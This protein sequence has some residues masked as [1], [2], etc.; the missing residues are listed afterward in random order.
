MIASSSSTP[1]RATGPSLARLVG[2]V[3]VER[4]LHHPADALVIIGRQLELLVQDEHLPADL[5]FGVLR[6]SLFRL[7]QGR[8][9]QLSRVCRSVTVYGEADI[10]P[11][12][13]PGVTFVALQPNTPLCQEW[14]LIVDSPGF[15]AALLTQAVAE[16]TGGTMRRYR[17]EGALSADERIVKRAGLLLS[18]M[19]Q[20]PMAPVVQRDHFANKARW[21][22]IAYGLATHP[23]C[24][25]LNLLPSL[26][27]LPYLLEILTTAEQ[28]DEQTLAE[29]IQV[30]RSA[31]TLGELCYRSDGN[32]LNPAVWSSTRPMAAISATQ[33]LAG[34][35]AQQGV[36]ALGTLL[37]GSLDQELLPDALSAIAVPIYV[38]GRVWGVL[39]AGLHEPEP[40]DAPTAQ[41]VVAVAALLGQIMSGRAIQQTSPAAMPSFAAATAPAVAAPPSRAVVPTVPANGAASPAKT[42]PTFSPP[43]FPAA[44]FQALNGSA[45]NTQVEAPA[46]TAPTAAAPGGF[47]L[48]A[49]MRG[50]QVAAPPSSTVAPAK[51]IP[52]GLVL[53]APDPFNDR[54]WP[55]LQKRMMGALIAFDQ[56][57]AEYV[58]QE[59]CGVYAT[60]EICTE[61]LMPVQIAV[62]E[63]WHRGEV[64][65]AAEHFTS[66]FV[67]GKL[68][69]LLNAYVDSPGGPLAVIGC[70]Q[71]ELHEL[72]A[73]MLSLF[74]RWSGFRVIYLGQNVPNTTIEEAIRQIRP[75]VLGLSATTI[76]AAHS[77]TEV[78][79]II[80]RVEPP[81]P[82][83][84]F[85]GMAFYERPDL[86]SR[87]AGQFLEG[88]IRQI[89]RQLADTFRK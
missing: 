1:S 65:V 83:F 61:L 50:G 8:I 55:M 82:M 2:D 86:R 23:E 5:S 33:G 76:E 26:Y 88:D 66:R 74:M 54:S 47:G 28:S 31:G 3:P 68:L 67:E 45:A 44:P 52:P 51:Q 11:P 60:E 56:R 27:D 38:Q 12:T 53:A 69:T 46:A 48:P 6:F 29:A 43:S 39:L 34:Q 30:L 58:W 10:E 36:P 13:M 80:A 35:A 24:K 78:G 7:H 15:W 4:R 25:R 79:Q 19:Q 18:L 72:G 89:V 77:L 70:A 71:N 14:F 73:I 57:S 9:A 21:A 85:G 59:A 37:A 42:A 62:G 84:I 22:Q 49:W 87:I 32:V 63:G 75:Q 40:H 64:S 20:Q 17:F 41:I 16:R 81:R